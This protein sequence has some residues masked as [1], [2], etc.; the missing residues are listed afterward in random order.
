MLPST[1][2]RPPRG[3]RL[4]LRLGYPLAGLLLFLLLTLAVEAAAQASDSFDGFLGRADRV[5][6]PVALVVAG[7]L[8]LLLGVVWSSSV[9]AE[10]L[11]A[12]VGGRAITLSWDDA[13][14][15][16]PRALV[17]DVVVGTDVVLLGAG[18][19]ELARVRCD[20]DRPA[21]LVALVEHGYPAP[22]TEDPHEE[23]F[24]PW[25][26]TAQDLPRQERRLLAAR[27]EALTDGAHGDAELL[28]RQLAARGVMVRDVH[29]PGRRARVQEW[30]VI[31]GALPAMSAR[32]ARDTARTAPARP[33]AGDTSS[34]GNE[35]PAARPPW[36]EPE[37]LEAGRATL[38]AALA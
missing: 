24:T 5:G 4:A 38:R 17:E 3:V 21:L 37:P 25:A 31:P 11:R 15:S 10:A 30:R 32:A 7:A 16:V 12:Q 35:R 13:R 22:R 29:R 26:R 2:V 6:E 18:T 19:V 8:G 36:H 33:R 34:L 28:R 27:G 9:L 1:T 14:V 23:V 20:L